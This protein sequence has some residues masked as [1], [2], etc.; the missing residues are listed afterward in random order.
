MKRIRYRDT[1]IYHLLS[2]IAWG[3]A[4]GLIVNLTK[5]DIDYGHGAIFLVIAFIDS[6]LLESTQDIYRAS[7]MKVFLNWALRSL[8]YSIFIWFY[9][10][11]YVIKEL[12]DSAILFIYFY[13]F[14]IP[15]FTRMMV[16]SWSA[17]R[18]KSNKV[19]YNTLIL[20]DEEKAIQ[21]ASVIQKGL[22]IPGQNI[23]GTV[24]ASSLPNYPYLGHFEQLDQ[25]LVKEKI[26]EVII[27]LNYHESAIL[28]MVLNKLRS[29]FPNVLIRITPDAYDFLMGH[30]K[31][32][33]L[34]AE[35]LMELPSGKMVQWQYLVKRMLDIAVSIL[36]LIVLIP[37][38]LWIIFRTK[39]SSKGKIFYQ[40]E[41]IGKFGKPFNILKFRSMLENAETSSP[42]L[43]FEGDP[44]CTP[45]GTFM[46]KWRLDEIPQF[47]NVLRGDMSIVGPRPERQFFIDQIKMQAP[48]YSRILT[49]HPGITSWGQVKYGYASTVKQMVERLKFDLIYVENQSLS[50]DIKIILYTILVLFQ[51]K[52]K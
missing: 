31:L 37:L 46:R 40:Q 5:V 11:S 43:S 17:R 2:V 26:E 32:D 7:R 14:S 45:W 1:L 28:N 41:R 3:L 20:G 9:L 34:Y 18:L 44:R 33:A 39:W 4:I 15:A 21:L 22:K 24:G 16:L 23:L 19:N 10:N 51:G 42:E 47:F 50:L 35:P 38:I 36:L 12:Q 27:A 52:G 6:F 25:I 30:I 48:F 8:V 13:L 49:V 29:N